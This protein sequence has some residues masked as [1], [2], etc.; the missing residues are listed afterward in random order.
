MTLK[1]RAHAILKHGFV[2][3][4][5]NLSRRTHYTV[6][7]PVVLTSFDVLVELPRGFNELFFKKLLFHIIVDMTAMHYLFDFVLKL[8]A[9]IVF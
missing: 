2:T 5:V 8:V 4:S 7:I 1:I 9:K 6:L 3:V